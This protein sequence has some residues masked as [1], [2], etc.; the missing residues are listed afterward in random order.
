MEESIHGST[1][2]EEHAGGSAVQL[3]EV[4]L[5]RGLFTD[6]AGGC[7]RCSEPTRELKTGTALINA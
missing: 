3:G 2:R 1:Q 4:Y 7:R 6:L 5:H